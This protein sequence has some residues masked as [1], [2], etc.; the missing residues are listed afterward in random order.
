MVTVSFDF[1]RPNDENIRA[2]LAMYEILSMDTELSISGF[3][4][5]PF[6][7]DAFGDLVPEIVSIGDYKMGEHIAQKLRII[8]DELDTGLKKAREADK[9]R[10]N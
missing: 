6:I 4:I 7:L 1:E 10:Q 3:Q 2:M 8:A 5:I 9:N